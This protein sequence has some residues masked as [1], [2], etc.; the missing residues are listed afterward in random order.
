MWAAI[1]KSKPTGT[2]SSTKVKMQCTKSGTGSQSKP[3]KGNWRWAATKRQPPHQQ[4]ASCSGTTAGTVE[5]I[6]DVR[7]VL[8]NPKKKLTCCVRVGPT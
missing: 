2:L 3:N 5:S 8:A 4:N 1:I 6:M 7:P